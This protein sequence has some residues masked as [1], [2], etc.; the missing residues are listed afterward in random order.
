MDLLPHLY[1]PTFEGA[2]HIRGRG[3]YYLTRVSKGKIQ[4]RLLD[5]RLYLE[6]SGLV[7]P[8][9]HK[10]FEPFNRIVQQFFASGIFSFFNQE[11]TDLLNKKRYEEYSEPGEILTI[12]QLEASFVIWLVSIGFSV[13][14]FSLEWLVRF[15]DYIVF[16]SVLDC[17]MKMSR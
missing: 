8:K 7:F 1:E 17:Y 12:E 6:V 2:I 13:A 9:N 4:E 14:A 3:L 10:F 11:A 5:H 16:K 15:R